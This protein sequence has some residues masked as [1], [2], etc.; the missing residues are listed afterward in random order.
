MIMFEVTNTRL[1]LGHGIHV[2]CI[3][4][5]HTI[6]LSIKNPKC[7]FSFACYMSTV[8]VMWSLIAR[9]IISVTGTKYLTT[10]GEIQLSEGVL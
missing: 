4:Q 5:I 3:V 1:D 2:H 7:L 10:G 8:S 9:I 6:N